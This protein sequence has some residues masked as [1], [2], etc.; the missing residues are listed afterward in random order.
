MQPPNSAGSR[1]N[2]CCCLDSQFSTVVKFWRWHG[3][4]TAQAGRRSV[5][6]PYHGVGYIVYLQTVFITRKNAKRGKT[7]SRIRSFAGLAATV[8]LVGTASLA[9]AT[10]GSYWNNTGTDDWSN[11]ADWTPSTI[12]RAISRRRQ[13]HQQWR[14]GNHRHARQRHGP[15]RLWDRHS[16]WRRQSRRQRRKWIRHHER[17]H[18]LGDWWLPQQ[19]RPRHGPIPQEVLGVA[20]G[21]G[22]FTQTG[23]INIPYTAIPK[24]T[25]YSPPRTSPRCRLATARAAT[26][27]TT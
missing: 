26:G 16:R 23:G 25:T 18:P 14:N 22:I 5:A 21:S 7:M 8:L 10:N 2:Q 19:F 17:W 11:P 24:G 3:R 4:E 6:F 12:S 13:R 9:Q 15:L 1:W 20:S 27:S